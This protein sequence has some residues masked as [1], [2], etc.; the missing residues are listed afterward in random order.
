MST[1]QQFPLRVGYLYIPK[2]R[3]LT[4]EGYV[5]QLIKSK[6]QP[7]VILQFILI[8][9][10]I[11][12]IFP[13][14]AHKIIH[15]PSTKSIND[16]KCVLVAMEHNNKQY[17]LWKKEMLNALGICHYFELYMRLLFLIIQHESNWYY[18]Y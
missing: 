10:F 5:K 13:S 2:E 17:E 1:F 9:G 15:S 7:L 6:K 12:E 14:I 18:F 8:I 3:R 16:L 4:V 11:D